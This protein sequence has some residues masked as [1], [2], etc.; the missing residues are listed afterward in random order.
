[1]KKQLLF[2]LINTIFCSTLALKIENEFCDESGCIPSGAGLNAY[3]IDPSNNFCLGS[4]T[5]SMG[6]SN[7]CNGKGSTIGQ[8][9]L[10]CPSANCK[11]PG[12]LTP[13][14]YNNKWSVGFACPGDDCGFSRGLSHTNVYPNPFAIMRGFFFLPLGQIAITPG[15]YDVKL[16]DKLALEAL[17]TDM[18]HEREC[19]YNKALYALQVL[20]NDERK[21]LALAPVKCYDSTKC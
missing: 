10:C 1:M 4:I 19:G 13:D 16:K 17:Q 2:L 20:K 8:A 3:I 14:L 21:P 11:I 12:D 5:A 7:A 18:W 6:Y 15:Q 9:G